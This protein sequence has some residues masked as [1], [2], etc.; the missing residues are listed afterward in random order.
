[1]CELLVRVIDKIGTTK[2]DDALLTKRGDV[3]DLRPDGWNWGTGELLNPDWRILRV[4][5]VPVDQATS[6]VASDPPDAPEE[7]ATVKRPNAYR[8]N[9]ESPVLQP[10]RDGW[11]EDATR[12]V[13]IRE[14]HLNLNQLLAL[15]VRKPPLLKDE[16]L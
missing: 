14:M 11:L 6:I 15:M 10:I 12:K 9:L 3:I 7:N 2:D 4:P 1:M 8:M 16:V 5:G 13:P